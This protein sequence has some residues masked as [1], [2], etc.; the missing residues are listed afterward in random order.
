MK[1]MKTLLSNGLDRR[2][3]VAPSNSAFTLIELLV[4]IAI[5]SILAS[6]LLPT[7][8]RGKERARETQCLNNLRQIGLATRLYWDDNRMVYS[9]VSGGCDPL[10]GCLA[11]NHNWAENRNLFYLLHRSEVF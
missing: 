8:T 4:V 5:I 10:P 1:N 2:H 11:T 9:F 7:L 3:P 6:M